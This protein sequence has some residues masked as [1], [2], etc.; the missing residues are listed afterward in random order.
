LSTHPFIPLYVDDY[1]AATAHLTLEEDGLYNRLLRLCWRTPGC[2]LPTDHAWIARKV[3]M[4]EADFDRVGK[5]ILDE[6][7]TVQR[8]RYVQRRLKAE[9]DDISRRKSARKLAGKK[10]GEAKAR[11]AKDNPP[12]NATVLPSDTRASHNHIHNQEP[13]LPPSGEEKA[14][15]RKPKTA[16][17]ACFPDEPLIEATR[18]RLRS[19]GINLDPAVQAERFRN[20]AIQNDRRCA[21][22]PAAWRNWISKAAETAPKLASVR[23]TVAR[24]GPNWRRLM[25]EF[26]ANGYWPSD[27][28]VGPKPGRP[29]C[30]VPAEVL[31]EFPANPPGE[32]PLAGVA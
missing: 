27:P 13:P 1:E 10:G 3:R 7:F 20:H 32:L 9:Y 18:Q 5:A 15:R 29:G 23:P 8:G 25:R 12:S 22:W 19:D 4:A 24:Q 28:D 30:I 14:P 6:F 2:S 11:N 17:P 21:D 26:R 16:I 31:A